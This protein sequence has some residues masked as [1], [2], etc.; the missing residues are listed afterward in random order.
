M[1]RAATVT[2]LALV[3]LATAQAQAR[4]PRPSAADHVAAAN[5]AFQAKKYDLALDEL[6]I[7]YQLAPR[8]EFLL[9]FAQI[10]RAAGQ[11][12]QALEACN[13]YLVTVPNG[14]MA[15]SA[16]KL[17][18]TLKAE[19]A[20]RAPSPPPPTP[21]TPSPPITPEPAAPAPASPTELVAT[22][23]ATAPT[24]AE[25]SRRRRRVVGLALGLGGLAVVGLAVGLGVGLGVS[26]SR[27]STYG[28]ID[29]TPMP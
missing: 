12:Q 26:Q 19:L 3:W 2:M 23:P 21:V 25:H 29:F 27:R 7:A 22:P 15:T 10:Y 1:T 4:A 17:A 18:E 20:A 11:L 13:S 6:R 8:P 5:R 9:T 16:R 24:D 14:P 28:S